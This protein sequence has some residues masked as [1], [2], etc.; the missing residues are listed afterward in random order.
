MSLIM[1][2][3]LRMTPST[4]TLKRIV[5]AYALISTFRRIQ[6]TRIN[7]GSYF[8]EPAKLNQIIPAHYLPIRSKYVHLF[9]AC[10]LTSFTRR[11]RMPHCTK[12]RELLLL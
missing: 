1:P 12:R 10:S 3:K 7:Q 6:H 5:S 8:I 9:P 11:W 2:T 4:L